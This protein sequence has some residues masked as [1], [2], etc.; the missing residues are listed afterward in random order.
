VPSQAWVRST[1]PA[2]DA[3][4]TIDRLK[5]IVAQSGD[6][7]LLA[8]GPPHP[9]AALLD[10]CADALS[11]LLETQRVEAARF[12]QMKVCTARGWT[13]DDRRRFNEE[14]ASLNELRMRARAPLKRIGKMS[15]C[16]AA[17]IYAKAMIVRASSTGAA[18]LAKSMA[19]D[20]LACAEL[21][22]ALWPAG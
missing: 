17:G 13:D 22:R 1:F 21:R 12:A 16:T 10:L 6:A 7:L 9:D 14:Y 20:F 8:N 18:V 19:K 15:A 5:A 3:Q 2:N 11:L 4:P